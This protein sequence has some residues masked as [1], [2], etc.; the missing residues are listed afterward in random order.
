[1]KKTQE[2]KYVDKISDSI[3]Q[4]FNEVMDSMGLSM[5]QQLA[6]D[7]V[8]L[9]TGLDSLGF[10]VLVARLEQEL[11]YDPFVLLDSPIYPKVFREFVNIYE[12]FAD[13]RKQ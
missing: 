9:E 1:M 8:L 6:D 7:T 5:K 4:Q 12:Q 13:R 11:G 3:R 10:A 2:G